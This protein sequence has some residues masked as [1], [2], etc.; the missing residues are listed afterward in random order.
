[1]LYGKLVQG[2]SVEIDID[3]DDFIYSFTALTGFVL[4]ETDRLDENVDF[5]TANEAHEYAR[6]N[7]GTVVIRS[8]TGVGYVIK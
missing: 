3:N 4:P 6:N 7:P 1:M 2:G 5:I 8:E